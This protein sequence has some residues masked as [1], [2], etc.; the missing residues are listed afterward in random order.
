M[1]NHLMNHLL[2]S[3]TITVHCDCGFYYTIPYSMSKTV[4]EKYLKYSVCP[5]CEKPRSVDFKLIDPEDQ[6]DICHLPVSKT[7][8]GRLCD[9][10][11]MQEYRRKLRE[12]KD[13]V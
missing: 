1:S 12:K 11:Y 9:N 3:K 10:H 7:R 5:S 2:P 13:L 8:K 4:L 6:C